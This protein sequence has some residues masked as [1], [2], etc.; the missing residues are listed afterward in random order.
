MKNSSNLTLT[1]LRESTEGFEIE[2]VSDGRKRLCIRALNE[3]GNNETLVDLWDLLDW[4]KFGPAEGRVDNGFV[5]PV[6]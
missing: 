1:G 3:G 2:L 6:K 5:I 4:L